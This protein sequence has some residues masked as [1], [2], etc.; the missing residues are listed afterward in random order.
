MVKIKPEKIFKTAHYA[1]HD[2]SENQSKFGET[3]QCRNL[4]HK[5]KFLALK[6]KDHRNLDKGHFHR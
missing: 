4:L 1:S 6:T 2:V 3:E 5:G